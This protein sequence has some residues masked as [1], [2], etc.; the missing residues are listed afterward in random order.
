MCIRDSHPWIAVLDF[1]SMYPSIMIGHNICYT[2]RI[3]PAQPNPPAEGQYHTSP[4]ESK[5]RLAEDRKGMVPALLED[6]MAQ[7]DEHKAAIKVAKGSDDAVA[8]AEAQMVDDPAAAA[9]IVEGEFGQSLEDVDVAASLR[10]RVAGG[11]KTQAVA[12]ELARRAALDEMRQL[13][14]KEGVEAP[15]RGDVFGGRRAQVPLA[16]DGPVVGARPRLLEELADRTLVRRERGRRAGQQ[17]H[18]HAQLGMV[19]PGEKHGP[20]RRAVA[21][22]VVVRDVDAARVLP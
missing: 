7:R 11:E 21:P 12:L 15:R 3:D 19:P 9:T 5:F 13:A 2:T 8:E 6:L 20:R 18:V 22:R 4:I 16:D 14:L 17:R 1:K 10:Q